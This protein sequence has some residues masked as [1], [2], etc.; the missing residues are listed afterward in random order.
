MSLQRG[1]WHLVLAAIIA[2]PFC[3][4]AASETTLIESAIRSGKDPTSYLETKIADSGLILIGTQ[5]KNALSHELISDALPALVR[6]SGVTV[7][8]VEIPSD[9]QTVIERYRKGLCQAGDIVIHGIVDSPAYRKILARAKDLGMEIIAVDN[10]DRDRISR[11][12]GMASRIFAYLSSHPGVKGLVVVGNCHV[13]KNLQW[14][15]GVALSLADHLKAFR[16]FSIVMWPGALKHGSPKALDT[17]PSTFLGIKDPTLRCMNIHQ[18]TSLAD[19]ADGVI[20][21]PD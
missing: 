8:F 11:D 18:K 16:P 17:D 5:H 3:M 15:G 9:Q 10:S 4:G 14:H 6:I 21:L 19:T 7:L 1:L 12:Q 2:L 13:L 20:L